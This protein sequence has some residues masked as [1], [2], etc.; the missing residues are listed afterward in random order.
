MLSLSKLS[1]KY[2]DILLVF[3][4]INSVFYFNYDYIN[5][6]LLSNSLPVFIFSAIR[7]FVGLLAVFLVFSSNTTFEIKGILIVSLY[8]CFSSILFTLDSDSAIFYVI[9]TMCA[10]GFFSYPST[11]IKLN[12]DPSRI[13]NVML[14]S[15]F[16]FV[17]LSFSLELFSVERMVSNIETRAFVCGATSSSRWCGATNNPNV[18][19]VMA[20]FTFVF[21]VFYLNLNNSKSRDNL[22][23]SI[24]QYS[25]A[26]M[27][28]ALVFA[29]Q[30]RAVILFLAILYVLLWGNYLNRPKQI[31]IILLST[32][33]FLLLIYSD[34]FLVSEESF[35]EIFNRLSD[36][37]NSV[38]INLMLGGFEVFSNNFIFGI[39]N[40]ISPDFGD[41]YAGWNKQIDSFFI[42]I[43]YTQGLFISIILFSLLVL[44]LYRAYKKC[45]ATFCVLFAFF[46]LLIIE[47]HFFK[48]PFIW[49]IMYILE[50][51]KSSENE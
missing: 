15:C 31:A 24:I 8:I 17:F 33:C 1:V 42:N 2:S 20:L 14:L 36:A 25:L 23:G 34:G 5:E 38:R 27:S 22:R 37:S 40:N 43:L 44:L 19:G 48:T 4:F 3:F 29:S 32:F 35:N 47:D 46:I 13:V 49:Y 18:L 6:F 39:G 45:Y 7:L 51:K 26:L 21:S 11:I 9:Q 10:I 50:P 28:V 16:S 41:Y 12:N 30:S